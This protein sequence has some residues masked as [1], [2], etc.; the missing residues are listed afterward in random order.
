MQ[1]QHFS[2]PIFQLTH[3]RTHI[4]TP[5]HLE[6]FQDPLIE[7]LVVSDS[8][9]FPRDHPRIVIRLHGHS[10]PTAR[11]R[12]PAN[13][14]LRIIGQLDLRGYLGDTRSRCRGLLR[15]GSHWSSFNSHLNVQCCIS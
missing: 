12:S 11:A 8:R 5:T 14:T 13:H 6:I 4:H 7:L 9:M 2:D 15:V 10:T 3:V 1:D